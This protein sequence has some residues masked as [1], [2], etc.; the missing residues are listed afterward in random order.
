VLQ[1]ELRPGRVRRLYLAKAAAEH[2]ICA[3]RT[4]G[5]IRP[6]IVRKTYRQ[7]RLRPPAP[8]VVPLSVASQHPARH[9]APIWRR[10]FSPHSIPP[11]GAVYPHRF[12]SMALA[13]FKSLPTSNTSATPTAVLLPCTHFTAG[14]CRPVPVQMWLLSHGCSRRSCGGPGADV[15]LSVAHSC[16]QVSHRADVGGWAP[17]SPVQVYVALSAQMCAP[18]TLA[19]VHM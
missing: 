7:H 14:A 13:K 19:G 1:A 4:I 12:A 10:S 2:G 15:R 6:R 11:G 16:E 5:H 9:R 17:P 8:A 3:I 18:V